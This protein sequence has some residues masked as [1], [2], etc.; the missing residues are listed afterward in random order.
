MNAG[1]VQA[2]AKLLPE[3]RKKGDRVL[4]FSQFVIMLDILEKVMDTLG[5]NY[6]RLDGSTQMSER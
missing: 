4:L 6:V 1:K 5:I 2:L 3:M